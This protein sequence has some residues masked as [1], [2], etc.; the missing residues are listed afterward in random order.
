[1]KKIILPILLSL[2]ITACDSKHDQPNVEII[3]NMMDG[4]DI[5]AQ[6]Y[7]HSK[8]DKRAMRLP[9]E[10]TLARGV[11]PYKYETPAEADKN[12]NPIRGDIESLARG[13]ELFEIYCLV[14]HG[15]KA[16]GNGTVAPKMMV[17]PPS[18]V[19]SKINAWTD[20]RIYHVITRGQGMMGSYATQIRDDERWKVVNYIRKLQKEHK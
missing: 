10:H 3:Q 6:D 1:M 18:L 11:K 8:A 2:A 4:P 20:G 9:P 7:D 5:K 17:K 12:Q 13:Q 14:C 15:P 16:L 19:T